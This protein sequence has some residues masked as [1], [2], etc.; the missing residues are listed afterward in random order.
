M[1]CDGAGLL[2]VLE[3]AAARLA[4]HVDEVNALNVYPVPDGDTGTNMLHTVRTA[5]A[6]A[7]T[8][9]PTVS[10]VAAAAAHGALMGARGNSGVILSQVIRGL[11]D[12]LERRDTLRA[13]ELVAALARAR[14]H[15]FNAV[16]KPAHGTMLTVLA[17]LEE[18]A[19]GAAAAM[20][21]D[22]L[23]RLLV[24]AGEPAVRATREQNPMNRAAGVVDAGAR[25]LWLL[26][27]GALAALD[28]HADA[29]VVVVTA[30]HPAVAAAPAE[31][32]SWEGAYDVQFLVERPTR[33]IA[34]IREEMLEY[35]ADCVLVVGDETVMKVHVHTLHPDEILRIGLTAG[36][37]AD[38]LVEDLD[39]MSA[40]HARETGIVVRPPLRPLA[41]VAIVPGDGFAAV[42]RSLGAI[43][44]KGGA[45]MNPSTEELLDA[46]R[47]ANAARTIVLPN[48]RNVV[49]AARQAASLASGVTVIATE[50][51]A[52]GMAA[53][54]AYDVEQGPDA[55]VG[56]MEAAA[57][58]AGCLEV[59]RAVRDAKVDG[60]AVREGDNLALLDGRVVAFGADELAV[61]ADGAAGLA[62]AELLTLYVGSAVSPE[63]AEAAR[64]RLAGA[65]PNAEVEVLEGGQP[66]YPFVIQAE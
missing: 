54:A 40:E 62:G 26:F 66:H 25:G 12:A 9:E 41:V 46:I 14:T 56:R 34:A 58:A 7:H 23:L 1:Q 13:D 24:R 55:A 36:R 6:H 2:R 61:L 28:G 10:A 39:A 63:R 21:V 42:A 20:P 60:R 48:D 37:L 30:A 32:A 50:N 8:A 35:G 27:D 65:C 19:R 64:A 38:L 31:V 52:Q 4:A 17:T 3:A 51:V 15:A 29:P 16:T 43:P 5:L 49:L 18:A 53:L 22:D 45:T 47:G 11:K 59:T 57:A 44:V 33:P